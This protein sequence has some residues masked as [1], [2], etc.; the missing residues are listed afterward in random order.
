MH[1]TIEFIIGG[2]EVSRY[3]TM[4]T[5][6]KETVG[7]HS[8]GVACLVLV[9][10]PQASRSLLIAALYHDLAEQY[11]G[12][13]P[14]PAKRQYGIGE[15]VEELERRMMT[16]AGIVFPDLTEREKRVLKLA[17]IAHGAL[18]CIRE[19]SLGNKNMRTV[20]NRFMSYAADMNP[21]GDEWL[22]FKTIGDM[23]NVSE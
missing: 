12:D 15:Q 5:I 21:R 1:K 19:I 6:Q 16:E 10:E 4:L 20:Y 7:H 8:H 18:S 9:L 22:L 23:S 14:S 2:S 3:H 17:D 11:T 13:I